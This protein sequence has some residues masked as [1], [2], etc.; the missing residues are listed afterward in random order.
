MVVV[1][2]H[3]AWMMPVNVAL[4]ACSRKLKHS[5]AKHW[6]GKMTDRYAVINPDTLEAMRR[7]GHVAK[8]EARIEKLEA[9][10]RNIAEGDIPRTVKIPFRDD[11]QSSKHDRCEHGQW[12]YEDCGCCIE[13][14]A[15]KAL[16][17]K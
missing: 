11:G 6:R 4:R 7:A 12:F 10:L 8:L 15:R 17:A 3:T 2:A 5:P 16:D 14:Y 1:V 13:D 9:A